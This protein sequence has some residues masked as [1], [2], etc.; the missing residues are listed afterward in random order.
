MKNGAEKW[1]RKDV[2]FAEE[3][4]DAGKSSFK[5]ATCLLAVNTLI[6]NAF[7]TIAAASTFLLFPLVLIPRKTSPLLPN[8]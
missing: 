7:A 4:K 1:N 6:S 3:K 2:L 5:T 8:P